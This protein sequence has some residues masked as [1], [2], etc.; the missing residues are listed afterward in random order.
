MF[1][2]IELFKILVYERRLRHRELRNK[3]NITR[4]FYTGYI[5]VVSKK[6]KSSRKHK[7]DQKIVL[8]TKRIYRVLEKYIPISY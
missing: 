2:K 3:V 8:K 1:R 4:G 7:L 5:V 6:M